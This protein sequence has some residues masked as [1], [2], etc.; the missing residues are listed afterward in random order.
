MAHTSLEDQSLDYSKP[1]VVG[2]WID[3]QYVEKET[4]PLKSTVK[5]MAGKFAPWNQEVRS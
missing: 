1:F 4:Y 5:A 2:L 3:D